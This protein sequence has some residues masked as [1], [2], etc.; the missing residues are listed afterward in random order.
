MSLDNGSVI[1]TFHTKT[2]K[3]ATIRSIARDDAQIATDFINKIS[4]EDSFVQFAGEHIPLEEEQRYIDS[5]LE[6]I[7]TEHAVKLLCIVDGKLAGIADV[8]RNLSARS[9]KLHI[10]TFG[11]IIA[12]EFRGQGIGEALM[13]MTID[14]AVQKM[15]GLKTMYLECFANNV[16]AL[17][18]YKKLGFEEVGRVPEA[19]LRQGEYVDAVLMVKQ[20]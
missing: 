9:R 11:M 10:G 17:S 12:K 18:L 15:P 8:H 16:P 19:L 13:R 4:Q 1:A 7:G 20:V 14:E 5:E 3:Q 2:G 6:L